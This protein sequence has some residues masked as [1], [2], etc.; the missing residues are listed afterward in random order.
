MRLLD[1][2]YADEDLR[3]ILEAGYVLREAGKFDE[4]EA[5][6]RGVAELLPASDVPRV[7]LGTVEAQRGRFAEA[8]AIYEEALK[9]SPQSLY[10]RVHHAE[11]LLFQKRRVEAEAE[12]NE[13]V[14]AEPDSP[15]SRTAR[16]LLDAADLICASTNDAADSTG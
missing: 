1:V 5:V 12:L 9:L 14:A 3:I 4:A 15:H 8:Q 7:A 13:I 6:F 2:R 10:A 16:A 11:A